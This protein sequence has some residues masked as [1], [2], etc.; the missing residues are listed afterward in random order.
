MKKQKAT[1]GRIGSSFDDFLSEE[2]I[3]DECE[4]Q[5]IKEIL[6]LQISKAMEKDG[7]SKAAMARRMRTSR[8]ALDRLLDTQNTSVTLHTLQ[9]A[10][11]ALGKRL[12][13][14]IVNAK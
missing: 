6:S 14:K 7:I 12:H 10:A 8:P 9:R 5:A 2:G 1:T 11:A 4:T 13:L 3:L